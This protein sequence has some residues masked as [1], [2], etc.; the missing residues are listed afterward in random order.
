MDEVS[1]I[2]DIAKVVF[3]RDGYHIPMV[4]V[5]GE[6]DKAFIALEQFGDTSEKRE[7]D[8]LNC[9]TWFACKHNVGDL[10]LIVFVSEAWI[11]TNLDVLPSQD[12]KRIEVLIINSLDVPT[13]EEKLLYF[14]VKRDPK[15]KVLDLK[16]LALPEKVE[17]KGRLLP[18]FQKG[19]QT[20]SPVHN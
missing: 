13:Q 4:F 19:Y 1:K 18:A 6:K 7:R 12:P 16:E 8:M 14:E 17:T 10:E 2:A 3:L 15:G 9:G 11:G 5:K 20:I